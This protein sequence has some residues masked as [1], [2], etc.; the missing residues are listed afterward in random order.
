MGL[1]SVFTKN[2]NVIEKNSVDVETSSEEKQI[3]NDKEEVE[4]SIIEQSD[5][6]LTSLSPKEIEEN[7]YSVFLNDLINLNGDFKE[8][9]NLFKQAD[10]KK[11]PNGLYQ[12]NG[13]INGNEVIKFFKDPKNKKQIKELKKMGF[14]PATIMITLT[15]YDIEKD[16]NDVKEISMSI[17]SFLEDDKQAEIEADVNTLN[18]IITEYKYNW[19]DEQYVNN[20]HMQVMDIKRTAMKNIGFYQKQIS[21]DLKKSGFVMTNKTINTNQGELEGKISYYRLSLYV[22]SFASFL[23]IML[24]ENF[25]SDYLQTKKEELTNLSDAYVKNY[26]EAYDFI[27]KEAGKSLEGN[28][29]SGIGIAG[30][31]IGNLAEKVQVIKEKKIDEWFNKNGEELKNKSQDMKNSFTRKFEEMGNPN[32]KIFI[33]KIEKLDSI[34]NKTKN[35]Y[36][37]NEKI[38]LEMMK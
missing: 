19:Q 37:D 17:L 22:Y 2:N 20:S 1:F 33:D 12:M 34:Y 21:E 13:F 28:L 4:T 7:S 35:I 14:N 32:I 26:N 16:I 31:T 24:L 6:M 5:Y 11:N 27:K 30:K 8:F 25:Q 36:F 10:K 38:Y 29:L 9:A 18:R 15:L 23:E 3:N